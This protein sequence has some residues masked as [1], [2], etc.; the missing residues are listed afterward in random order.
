MRVPLLRRPALKGG[1]HRFQGLP[2]RRGKHIPERPVP[3]TITVLHQLQAGNTR[4][5]CHRTEIPEGR[6]R[7]RYPPGAKTLRPDGPEQLPGDP[8]S[9]IEVNDPAGPVKTGNIMTGQQPPVDG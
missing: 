1:R 9:T 7:H 5:Q 3:F 4:H 8:A 6:R 2:V